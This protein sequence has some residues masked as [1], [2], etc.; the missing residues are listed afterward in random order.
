MSTIVLQG[1][2]YELKLTME[3]VK[4]LNRVIQGGPMGIIGKAMM[5]DLEAFP[6]IVHAGLFH[7]EK[8][9]SLKDVEAEIEQAMMNEQLDSDVIYKI[10]NKV[11]TESFFFRNQAKKLVADNPEAAKALEMLRA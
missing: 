5:G 11:V 3:S 2:E 7:C 4:Y 6:Q 8:E 10:S 9:F 1:K